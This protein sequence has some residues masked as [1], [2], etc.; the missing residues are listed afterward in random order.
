[1]SSYGGWMLLLQAE[2]VPVSNP[3]PSP[4]AS[5]FEELTP[6]HAP[7]TALAV[8]SGDASFKIHVLGM[9]RC[10]A[11]PAALS[12]VEAP[13]L[14]TLPAVAEI[15]L[16]VA[17]LKKTEAETHCPTRGKHRRNP[18]RVWPCPVGIGVFT[19]SWQSAGDSVCAWMELD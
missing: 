5:P 12:L 19:P 15:Q 9:P 3:P 2:A 10:R 13:C 8:S 11:P 6:A 18:A 17:P 4:P 7:D 16:S 14:T 1:M